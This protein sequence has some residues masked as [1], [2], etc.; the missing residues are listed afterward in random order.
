MGIIGALLAI[1]FTLII[2]GVVW[3]G[4][5]Q[6]LPLIPLAPPFRTLVNVLLTV[7]LVLIVLWVILQLLG[8]V[9]VN[10]P[11]YHSRI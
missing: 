4:V 3:W 7:I 11:L 5:Q 1:V 2:V 10:V 6:L 9:G 8:L